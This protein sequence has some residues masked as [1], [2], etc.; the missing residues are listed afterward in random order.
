MNLIGVV[1]ALATFLSVWFGHV[2]VRKV[3]FISPTIWIPATLFATSGL[4]VEY[5]SLSTASR[6]LSTAL[7]IFG[8]TLLI[9]ALQIP[10][11][12]K[13]VIK[14]HAPAN[15][16]NPRHAKILAE[17][18]SATTQ[19]PLKRDPIGQFPSTEE[20]NQLISHY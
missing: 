14:G 18:P 13:R 6:P 15:P 3:E 9:D 7:G 10:L 16:K 19:D 5:L 20:A 8:I 2:A 11:Q 12:Q 17:F 1:A 4:F